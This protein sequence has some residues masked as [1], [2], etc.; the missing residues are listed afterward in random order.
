M[1]VPNAYAFVRLGLDEH[2]SL[3]TLCTNHAGDQFCRARGAANAEALESPPSS[4]AGP[5]PIRWGGLVWY[6]NCKAY[7]VWA[8]IRDQQLRGARAR[9]ARVSAG[10]PGSVEWRE[11]GADPTRYY[12]I[13]GMDI[14]H[15]RA[16]SARAV[17]GGGGG[18]VGASA[19]VAL[20]GGDFVFAIVY[21]PE[22]LV[23][24]FKTMPPADRHLNEVLHP[25]LPHRCVMDIERD[26][27]AAELSPQEAREE[28]QRMR[29]G[30][31]SVFV[32]VLVAFFKDEMGVR[33]MTP[34]CC[35]V[36]D[37]SRLGVKFSVHLTVR[38][39]SDHVFPDRFES[40]V[41]MAGLA[42]R[43]CARAEH[44][45][46]LR[47][48]LFFRDERNR[49][50]CTWDFGVYG[51][52]ARQMR[53]LGSCKAKQLRHSHWRECRV[54]DVAPGPYQ[55]QQR[56]APFDNFV[57]S[58]AGARPRTPMR[59]PAALCQEIHDWAAAQALERDAFWF[60]NSRRLPS[61]MVA[62]GRAQRGAQSM[63][64]GGGGGGGGGVNCGRGRVRARGVDAQQAHLRRLAL[65]IE[66][67]GG[68]A[69]R[70]DPALAQHDR[71]TRLRL[72]EIGR[73][74][75][76][77]IVAAA[78]PAAAGDL[79]AV[80]MT[81]SADDGVL[82]SVRVRCDVPELPGLRRMC[83]LG[84]TAGS[85]MAEASLMADFSVR[86]FCFACR[87]ELG[88][89]SPLAR[90][91]E[92][93]PRRNLAGICPAD[94]RDGFIDYS[95]TPDAPG[96]HGS[97][98]MREVA[99]LPGSDLYVATYEEIRADPGRRRTVILQGSMGSGKTRATRE[100]LDRVRAEKPNPLIL[101]FSFRQMLATMFATNFGLVNY[102]DRRGQ[103]S[104][105]GE[106]QLAIQ[107][108]SIH[109]LAKH[110]GSDPGDDD[111][112]GAYA[113]SAPRAVQQAIVTGHDVVIIDELESVLSHFS[114]ETMRARLHYTWRIFQEIVRA[115]RCLVVCDQDIGPRAYQ[116]LRSMRAVR[117][118]QERGTLP[119]LPNLEYHFNSHVAIKAEF[120][121]YLG[122]AE[123]FAALIG[124]LLEGK[125]VFFFS[126]NK[127]RMR[128]IR[129]LVFKELVR[130]R[131]ERLRELAG[132]GRAA[133]WQDD[134]VV[135][136]I[137]DVLAD[138]VLLIDQ[139]ATMRKKRA[140]ATS[141]NDIWTNYRMVM[142]SPTVGA[143]IDFTADH[144]HVAFG[145][146][147]SHSCSARGLNQMRGRVRRLL[148]GHV[149][150]FIK[151]NA[152]AE[153]RA[154]LRAEYGAAAEAAVAESNPRAAD[155]GEPSDGTRTRPGAGRKRMR[156][157]AVA[158]QAHQDGMNAADAAFATS[159]ARADLGGRVGRRAASRWGGATTLAGALLELMHDQRCYVADQTTFTEEGLI[160]GGYP[161]LASRVEL[162]ADT[163][164][165][166]LA[167]NM[168]EAN[169][170]L[171]C[172]RAE[173]IRVLRA[174]DPSCRYTFR[175]EYNHD[176]NLRYQEEV[177]LC[178]EVD[179]AGAQIAAAAQPEVSPEE[180]ATLLAE[181]RGATAEAV[182]VATGAAEPS[183]ESA[184]PRGAEEN[185]RA[186]ILNRADVAAF[187]GL[188][189]L[190]QGICEQL[191]RH[192]WSGQSR[193]QVENFA[194][195]LCVDMDTLHRAAFRRGQGLGS[196]HV[197]TYSR[198][199]AGGPE[200]ELTAPAAEPGREIGFNQV[201]AQE[202]WPLRHRMRWW[203]SLL[204]WATG[205]DLPTPLELN[206]PPQHAA[207]P[208]PPP[209]GYVLIPGL[210]C[211][212]AHTAVA[213][214][215]LA[216][217]V[218][219]AALTDR[220]P[221][222]MRHM[223]L[224]AREGTSVPAVGEAWEPKHLRKVTKSFFQTV[225]NLSL[226]TASARVAGPKRREDMG[227]SSVYSGDQL[228][229]ATRATEESSEGSGDSVPQLDVSALPVI[230]AAAEPYEVDFRC[231][232]G[233]NAHQPPVCS[234]SRWL[235]CPRPES[236]AVMLSL[237][238]LHVTSPWQ[239]RSEEPESRVVARMSVCDAVRAWNR[240]PLFFAHRS[241]LA[242]TPEFM[243][244]N[245]AVARARCLA[246]LTGEPA[247][248]TG[249]EG[250]A[251]AAS[252]PEIA[253][254]AVA[255]ALTGVDE[256]R[257]RLWKARDGMVRQ[258]R[259]PMERHVEEEYRR[260]L[261]AAFTDGNLLARSGVSFANTVSSDVYALHLRRAAGRV[262]AGV[263]E[264]RR[265][266]IAELSSAQA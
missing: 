122:E 96:G 47:D 236:L 23:G 227:A 259:R 87:R 200:V 74:Y 167:L 123:W 183:A 82:L 8:T 126:N 117:G 148:E 134:K 112:G 165:M 103:R 244:P 1:S 235:F 164:R 17:G 194:Y 78:H 60:Q 129:E 24:L 174:S 102:L 28:L 179:A 88:L 86:Y 232:R 228:S 92:V 169:R 20:Q 139:S 223:G 138:R 66:E 155:R 160:D 116:F 140:Q 185:R 243:G 209:P 114:S 255:T 153:L 111:L 55:E 262:A 219:Q 188:H 266:A 127:T 71:E 260:V 133:Y 61:R 39:P 218:V 142:I 234:P 63:G 206:A 253:S 216:N 247:P 195:L 37:S 119:R 15:H 79:A 19:A 51:Q 162:I 222:I 29:D 217:P 43:L 27:N 254:R 211:G 31:W 10:L 198:T 158:G 184:L 73:V 265:A 143:G 48:W 239:G 115:C 241:D 250:E 197:A 35:F 132:T 97:R 109:R 204:L 177:R 199:D 163:L 141:C 101:A 46:G 94:F 56:A 186:L 229:Q 192:G 32:P 26:F 215:R 248:P 214:A 203:V 11:V 251:A 207:R 98:F 91:L 242:H 3:S 256:V 58:A 105:F 170:S 99:K 172:F 145:W 93:P 5:V 113:P 84:C 52:G 42:R 201:T 212:S 137:N 136:T 152:D 124:V 45:G 38:T 14:A 59:V 54:F 178:E 100:F 110:T 249:E 107:L 90:E 7:D 171:A 150:V 213:K 189:G 2:D 21:T 30:L 202:I 128:A 146:A 72:L 159:E 50:Q 252:Q 16:A 233:C 258:A 53:L 224:A 147:T 151:D 81:G 187:Y 220:M 231:T 36:A 49:L 193:A 225:F 166:T 44:D 246:A 135:A 182:A 144:F 120:H 264:R 67:M 95:V 154:E 245:A 175:P 221:E 65:E 257:D 205:F 85:H 4:D 118:D 77:T 64:Q 9:A 190:D 238:F 168:V 181:E 12:M 34:Q 68:P 261:V 121:D 161:V 76:S 263:A 180:H 125:N 83:L 149:H 208:V 176:K 80:P 40:W 89:P 191:L 237:T 57:S 230:D 173:F 18:G 157:V 131:G 226:C 33:E 106:R 75:L 210:G 70:R 41:A 22:Q 6:K 62:R 130:L 104:L 25:T 13:I 108:E 196:V 156:E 69:P 240:W